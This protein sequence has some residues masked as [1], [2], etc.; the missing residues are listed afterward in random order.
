[1]SNEHP[2]AHHGEGASPTT[3]LAKN[4]AMV[5]GP[6][7][8][9]AGVVF[10]LVGAPSLQ[11]GYSAPTISQDALEAA[12]GQ[13]IQ[14]IGTVSMGDANRPVAGGE[15][16]YKA[17]CAACHATGAAGAPKFQDAGAWGARIAQ[18]LPAL[19]NSA[20]KGKGAMGAQG[21]GSYSDLEI[22][23]AV[24]YMANA[25][26]AKF[27]E[28]AAPAASGA[29]AAAEPAASG[30]AVPAVPAPATAPVAAASSTVTVADTA[31]LKVEGGIVKM[32]FA[33]GKADLAEGAKPAL[34]TLVKSAAVGKKLVVSGY[35]DA[36]GNAT[37]NAELAKKRAIAVRD[38]LMVLGV[39]K[40]NIEMKKPTSLVGDGSNAEARRVEVQVQ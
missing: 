3:S 11:P 9:V 27:A 19:I 22:S 8:A 18:G 25:G 21:G 10:Y 24:V 37:V 35:H 2:T 34:Q 7:L 13:R 30:A 36:K 12:T 29:A 28:P 4:V 1:M 14:K 39:D 16:V 38:M 26:G 32:Y 40:A 33:S 31:S 23:R 6:I 15:E 20:L 5:L 17:Q